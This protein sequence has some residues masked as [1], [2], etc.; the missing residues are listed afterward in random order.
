MPIDGKIK[1]TRAAHFVLHLHQ[2]GVDVD[3][4]VAA[5]EAKLGSLKLEHPHRLSSFLGRVQLADVENH[6][7]P[8]LMW[9]LCTGT[10]VTS[11]L[12][13]DP[14]LISESITI[15]LRQLGT[16]A[17]P[18][19]VQSLAALDPDSLISEY[20]RAE[21]RIMSA[22]N[23]NEPASP[24]E[25]SRNAALCIALKAAGSDILKLFQE[26]ILG[27]LSSI[28][29]IEN[30]SPELL[31]II[32]AAAQLTSAAS[33]DELLQKIFTE[34]PWGYI[35]DPRARLAWRQVIESR[36]PAATQILSEE[37]KL[38]TETVSNNLDVTFEIEA[39]LHGIQNV[40]EVVSSLCHHIFFCHN[41]FG[42]KR[43]YFGMVKQMLMSKYPLIAL[44]GLH[45][46]K[47]ALAS[48]AQHY[49][50]A[51]LDIPQFSTAVL[52]C[53][54]SFAASSLNLLVK[55]EMAP[56]A[57][58]VRRTSGSGRYLSG[59]SS[60]VSLFALPFHAV[61][62]SAAATRRLV[63]YGLASCE[64]QIWQNAA[65]LFA[66]VGD[67][68]KCGS[69]AARS[70]SVNGRLDQD[71]ILLKLL[72]VAPNVISG[73]SSLGNVKNVVVRS[74]HECYTHP[75]A[76]CGSGETNV[77][78]WKISF[79]FEFCCQP[80]R[81]A[82]PRGANFGG[83]NPAVGPLR[84][85]QLRSPNL[86]KRRCSFRNRRRYFEVRFSRCK[87]CQC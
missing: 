32:D 82:I 1:V 53:V 33:D 35:T 31:G 37:W 51:M 42:L 20:L 11:E 21:V 5:M 41:L 25:C 68:L 4:L 87:V 54:F 18:R 17:L 79:R 61:Q 16:F 77:W 39:I 45:H 58:A 56:Y 50:T 46:V 65:V 6:P 63:L 43:K 26:A 13:S 47:G 2:E 3:S 57:E 28:R 8:R 62:I 84:P 69:P 12:I 49:G 86:A 64:A 60:A 44:L 40:D 74:V 36:G 29:S 27:R 34:I 81:S 80:F 78:L 15:V 83:C 71:S 59:L 30:I 55:P 48:D 72:E 19:V 22:L 10:A 52:E 23:P 75:C 73:F 67:I 38:V 76:V 14:K 7:L 85:R 70:V 66:I 9:H 24:F